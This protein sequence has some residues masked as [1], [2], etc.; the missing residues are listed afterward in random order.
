MR[1]LLF[2]VTYQ[3]TETAGIVALR[4]TNEYI[5]FRLHRLFF[6]YIYKS[7]YKTRLLVWAFRVSNM[8]YRL[9]ERYLLQSTFAVALQV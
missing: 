6:I 8:G 4:L 2:K 7:V 5:C 3:C 1:L 9:G